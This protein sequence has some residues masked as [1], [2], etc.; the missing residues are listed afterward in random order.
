MHDLTIGNGDRDGVGRPILF[1][2]RGAMAIA[3]ENSLQAFRLGIELGATGLESDVHL[4]ADGTPMLVHDPVVDTVD[5]PVIVARAT[6][7]DL[8]RLGIPTLADL[9][10]ACGTAWPLS[11]DINDDRALAAAAAVIAGARRFGPSAVEGLYL[12]HGRV[13]VLAAIAS[14]SPDVTLVHS[15]GDEVL[16][17]LEAHAR[18]LRTIGVRVL[19]LDHADWGRTG[20]AAEAVATVHGAGCLAFAWDTQT[21]QAARTMV[22]AGA[23]GIYANDPR[24]LVAASSRG[25]DGGRL[26]RGHLR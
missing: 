6:V 25:R 1:A 24:V 11:L 22:E 8:R 4:A 5:G 17:T 26:T 16:G 21:V 20:Q 9:Y 23:D 18:Y 3:P 2:H 7:A 10:G 12:C 14:A 13:D 15:A 19:N